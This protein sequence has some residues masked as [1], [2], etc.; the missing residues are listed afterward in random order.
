[1]GRR[2]PGH[3]HYEYTVD[4]IQD[5]QSWLDKA[6]EAIMVLEAN[7][8]VVSSLQR[9]YRALAE[10][11]DFPQSLKDNCRDD[12]TEFLAHL[13]EVVYDFKAHAARAKLL[14]SSVRDRRELVGSIPQF[15]PDRMLTYVVCRSSS[16]SKDK[17]LRGQ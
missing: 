5:L 16:I 2:G 15:E 13:D 14:A 12:I 11:R 6:N 8:E 3:V 7:T 17:L 10:R 4:N 9:Y 1:V